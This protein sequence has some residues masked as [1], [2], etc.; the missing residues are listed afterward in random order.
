[1]LRGKTTLDPDELD[2]KKLSNRPFK[3]LPERFPPYVQ[4]YVKKM[5]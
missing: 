4:K 5:L 3:T 2:K 1:M